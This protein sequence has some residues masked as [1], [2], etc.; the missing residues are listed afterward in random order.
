MRRLRRVR[1]CVALG[2]VV[3]GAVATDARADVPVTGNEPLAFQ[4]PSLA[5]D[6]TRPERVA[7]AYQ[8][9]IGLRTCYLAL[10]SD[11]G[12]RWRTR[13]LIG[14]GGRFALAEGEVCWK[15][16]LAFG[17]DG[18]LYY[19]FQNGFLT[20][21]GGRH[22][23][24]LASRDGGRSFAPPR[25]VFP[26][27]GVN[28]N[29]PSVAVDPVTGRVY[30]SWTSL[31]RDP[32]AAPQASAPA[33][34]TVWVAASGDGG[35]TFG[36]PAEPDPL[37]RGLSWGSLVAVG[38]DGRVHLAYATSAP[39][40]AVQDQSQRAFV[41]ARSS[42]G[43]R[44]F[45]T[46]VVDALGTSPTSGDELNSTG[47]SRLFALARGQAPGDLYV[48][49][50]RRH[51]GRARIFFA[52]SRDGGSTLGDPRVVPRPAG[53][54]AHHQHRP[55]FAVEPGGRVHLVF[56]DRDGDDGPQHVYATRSDDG[57]ASFSAPDRLTGA[58][59][60]SAVG[61]ASETSGGYP[62][63]GDFLAAD[64]GPGGLIA[65][66][67]DSRRGTRL[68]AKQ[69]IF[70]TADPPPTERLGLRVRPRVV[71]ARVRTRLRFA[72]TAVRHHMSAPVRGALVRFAG[73]R[74]RTGR[75]GRASVVVRLRR[76]RRHVARASARGLADATATVRVVRRS[77][78]HAKRR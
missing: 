46:R 50:W 55:W 64:A 18:S 9:G 44:T 5:V 41:L 4:N 65:A 77:P 31:R 61:P 19:V 16:M 58:A 75:R 56:Y 24:I 74:L 67:T 20:R 78:E 33:N 51:E 13:A 25:P 6:P 62:T 34:G 26:Q 42:D 52:A 1:F 32:P 8:E 28:Q 3:A 30:V 38:G 68:N 60:D 48:A 12:R 72:V 54:E 59:S 7:I 43:A 10:S 49:W 11:G 36:A 57:G 70:V 73:R 37:H 27:D 45:A 76:A 2:A 71:R 63:F 47:P 15:P 23:V 35:T 22:V 66:W 29:W 53:A 14:A 17:P 39:R 69:D 40:L 21:E